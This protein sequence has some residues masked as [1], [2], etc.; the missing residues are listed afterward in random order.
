MYSAV[1]GAITVLLRELENATD[2]AFTTMARTAWGT[3]SLVSGQSAYVDDL[4]QAI[5]H[6]IDAVKPLVEQK[7]YL[8][9]FFD[10]ASR[11]GVFFLCVVQCC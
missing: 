7:R 1:S 11:Y 3:L 9:N 6:V 4:V 5:E 2:G 10:K 8:R